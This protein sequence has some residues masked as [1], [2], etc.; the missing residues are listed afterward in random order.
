MGEIAERVR[1]ALQLGSTQLVTYPDWQPQVLIFR[2]FKAVGNIEVWLKG[3]PPGD[4]SVETKIS[5]CA[6]TNR[7]GYN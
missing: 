7:P 4:V 3:E 2:N 6:A 1:E 5:L